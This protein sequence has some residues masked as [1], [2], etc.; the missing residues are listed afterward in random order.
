MVNKGNSADSRAHADIRFNAIETSLHRRP[1]LRVPPFP[2]AKVGQLA[3]RRTAGVSAPDLASSIA[4][5]RVGG[6][7]W[8]AQPTL[9]ERYV[10]ARSIKSLSAAARL[11][12]TLLL[13]TDRPVPENLDSAIITIS[14][15][16]DP[17]HML[18]QASALVADPDDDLNL[19]AGLLDIPAYSIDPSTG[20]PVAERVDAPRSLADELSGWAYENPFTGQSMSAAEAVE[21]CGFW[22]HLVDS[23]RDIAGGL[24]FAFWKQQ[25]VGPLLWNGAGPFAFQHNAQVPEAGKSIAVWRSKAPAQALAQLERAGVPL[26]EVEDGFLRSR[27]LGAD[28]IPPLSITVDS[29]SAYFDPSEPSELE[30]LLQN[31]KFDAEMIER[32][33][34]LRQLIVDEGIGKYEQ[35][36]EVIPRPAGDRRTILVAGQVEDDRAVTLGG[37]GLASNLELLAK[38][39]ERASDAY[40][41]YKPH[42]DVLAGHR[43]GSVSDEASLQHADEVVSKGSIGSL[44]AMVDQVH[45]NTSLAGFE[46]LLRGTKV[47]TYGV[48]FYAGWG[49][50]EDHGPIPVRRTAR[51]SLDELVAATLLIYPRYLDPLSGLPCPAEVVVSR[52][53][54][55]RGHDASL[56]VGVRRLQGKLMRRLRSLVQ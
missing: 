28:C 24:G 44:I 27:G 20:L 51:R 56:L 2:G 13:W 49:L 39:R 55:G 41:L 25:H 31:G 7:Y 33:T 4:R 32:A 38:V 43:R 36:S 1:F 35:G 45:V 3:K 15:D 30:C 18:G 40:I 9:P 23:N 54:Q 6:T 53:V 50:T 42:P 8:A 22:R 47:S 19:I 14:G 10:L 21:L 37:C 11:G 16:C 5:C 26:V 34:E 46:A 52:L 17:W 29:K 48:P 12:S